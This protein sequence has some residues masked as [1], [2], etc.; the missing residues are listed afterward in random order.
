[1]NKQYM[2]E[3][4]LKGNTYQGIA[5]K[6]GVSRQRVQQLLSPPTAIRNVVY[7]KANGKCQSCGVFVGRSGHIHHI[8]SKDENYN[9]MGNLRLL[10]VS[11]HQRE[12][13]KLIARAN[14]RTGKCIVCGSPAT[15][16]AKYCSQ[17]CFRDDHTVC[18]V[19]DNCGKSFTLSK[20]AERVKVLFKY[21]HRFCS[22]VCFVAY[23][24]KNFGFINAVKE[25]QQTQ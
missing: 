2:L 15:K 1:M 24:R 4:R 23:S 3:L 12:H 22:R 14:Y 17:L 16:F 21:E 8:G 19:C 5:E 20:S 9:D 25:Q 11:C 13:I 6:A 18:V 7:E 10:C